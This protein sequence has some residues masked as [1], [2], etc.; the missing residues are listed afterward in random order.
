MWEDTYFINMSTH[1]IHSI[2]THGISS[3]RT[4]RGYISW[5]HTLGNIYWY[6]GYMFDIL[7]TYHGEHFPIFW[8][9]G[10]PISWVHVPQDIKNVPHDVLMSW[11][12]CLGE[13]WIFRCWGCSRCKWGCSSVFFLLVLG[14]AVQE[15]AV[16]AHQN[17][18]KYRCSSAHCTIVMVL[19]FFVGWY[20]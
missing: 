1:V 14:I 11:G 16:P 13:H 20:P 15:Y 5:V 4:W 9:L 18:S 8:C 2:R 17:R 7:G 6:R 3:L 19:Q 12:P 10:A